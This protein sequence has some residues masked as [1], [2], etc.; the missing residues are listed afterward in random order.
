MDHRDNDPSGRP[1]S[2]SYSY[3]ASAK[4]ASLQMRIGTVNFK[5]TPEVQS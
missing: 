3:D 1:L 2:R 4:I 5:L